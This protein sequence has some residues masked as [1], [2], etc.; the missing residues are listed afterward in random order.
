MASATY[1]ARIQSGSLQALAE[2]ASVGYVSTEGSWRSRGSLGRSAD[3][4]VATEEEEEGEG[5]GAEAGT[6]ELSEQYRLSLRLPDK[7]CEYEHFAQLTAASTG[8]FK[9]KISKKE[10]AGTLGK[11]T[12]KTKELIAE[13]MNVIESLQKLKYQKLTLEDVTSSYDRG[14]G[15]K[16][17]RTS[18]TPHTPHTSHAAKRKGNVS[19]SVGMRLSDSI[20]VLS[21]S[22]A[23]KRNP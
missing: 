10:K 22:L 1:K 16:G 3:V 17:S 8:A 18:H 6:E 14:Q 23:S 15:K 21:D 4:G 7:I 12:A 11:H 9:G 13:R 20:Q 5:S 2:D 19:V